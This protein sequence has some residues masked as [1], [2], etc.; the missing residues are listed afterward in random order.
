MKRLFTVLAV[1][2]GVV[3]T[4]GIAVAD[5]E[6]DRSAIRKAAEGALKAAQ[7][8]DVGRWITFYTED[9]SLF[10]PNEPVVKGKE[11]IQD[12][13]SEAVADP[14]FAV[15]WQT[16]KVEVSGGGDLGFASGTYE[17]TLNDCEG[18]SFTER[19]KWVAVFKKE[20]D[21]TWKYVDTIWNTDQP[22]A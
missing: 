9:A 2:V 4:T 1:L 5:E 14:D 7:A 18:K 12:W 19:G 6:C 3:L 10:P 20:T 17:V 16:T 15:S 8:K 21:E 22:P 11:A 13:L